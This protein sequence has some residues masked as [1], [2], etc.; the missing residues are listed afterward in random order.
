[1]QQLGLL[2]EEVVEVVMRHEESSSST[3]FPVILQ[4]PPPNWP[5]I[6]EVHMLSRWAN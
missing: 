6:G 1:M 2:E 4:T 3:P 5:G